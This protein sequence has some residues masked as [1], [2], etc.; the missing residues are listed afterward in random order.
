MTDQLER[1][2]FAVDWSQLCVLPARQSYIHQYGKMA[3][4]QEKVFSVLAFYEMKSC[5]SAVTVLTN[6]QDSS[7]S[8]PSI[9]LGTSVYCA[10][11]Q[12]HMEI[13]T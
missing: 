13:S 8:Q 7:P 3:S 5:Y 6:V 10:S 4:G 11:L 9:M 2:Q 12:Q 1:F